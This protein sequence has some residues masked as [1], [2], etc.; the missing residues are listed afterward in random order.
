MKVLII[1]FR[2][3]GDVLLATPLISNLK[4]HYPD[5]EIDF[6]LNKGCED[7]VSNNPNINKIIIYDRPRIKRLGIFAQ[8]KEEIGFINR[9]RKQK[10]DIVIN[11]TEG[12]R[13]AVLA[14]F[15]KAKVKL[16]FPIRK[17]VLSRTKIF[18]KLGD[19]KQWQ[20]T[21]E[22][23]LQFIGLLGKDVTNKEVS[24]YW[25]ETIEQEIHSILKNNNVS[26]FVHIHPVSR[27]MFKC[28][29][30]DRMA[31]IIDFL[32]IEKKIKVVITVAPIDKEMDRVK[33]ILSLCKSK[34]IDLSGKLTLKHV[35]CLSAKAKMFF[36]IDSAP[37]HIAAATNTPVLSIF[38]ASF[39]AKW[40]PWDNSS[41]GK[42][43]AD[44]DG[45]QFN[46]KHAIVSNMTNEIF[47]ENGIKKSRGMSLVDYESVKGALN[48]ML[49]S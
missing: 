16:G 26:D 37:M 34:P 48:T 47:Y 42:Y 28:W 35:A 45:V 17:G 21:V 43:F 9:V 38:G 13:G 30:D 40:A 1:K 29:E 46:G 49:E 25:P 7:V 18:D 10:Y 19:D 3:I 39:P 22:K 32:Q 15:S 36:G 4:Y 11:L 41:N 6:A 27:W 20:H 24:I 8:L 14:L 31:K 2:N 33:K 23:D 5:S 12:D 44:Q